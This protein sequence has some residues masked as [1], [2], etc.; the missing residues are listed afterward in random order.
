[1]SDASNSEGGPDNGGC[2]TSGAE[3]FE[4]SSVSLKRYVRFRLA[5]TGCLSFIRDKPEGPMPRGGTLLTVKCSTER[6]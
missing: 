6:V 3:F 2:A 1:M 5:F 4:T